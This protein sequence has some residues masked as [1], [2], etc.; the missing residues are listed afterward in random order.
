MPTDLETQVAEAKLS[1]GDVHPGQ[2]IY[3]P[4]GH[5]RW[6]RLSRECPSEYHSPCSDKWLGHEILD[7]GGG[8]IP[9]VTLEKVLDYLVE[10]GYKS[11]EFCPLIPGPGCQLGA[12]G[13]KGRV[14]KMV[15]DTPTD[16]ACAAL[17]ASGG[18]KDD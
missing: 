7:C 1:C 8:R 17:L 13:P 6:P 5:L 12:I 4:D 3:H 16:A 9:D 11:M 2:D 14:S 15:E 10:M 18:G